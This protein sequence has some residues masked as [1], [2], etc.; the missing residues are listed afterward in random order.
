MCDES[1]VF[2]AVAADCICW[3][4]CKFA[5]IFLNNSSLVNFPVKSTLGVGWDVEG[6]SGAAAVRVVSG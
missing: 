1:F 2:R 5:D 3:V 6:F 4:A